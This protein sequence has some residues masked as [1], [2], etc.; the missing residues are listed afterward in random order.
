MYDK[1][2][3]GAA[4]I[5]QRDGIDLV[6]VDDRIFAIPATNRAAQSAMLESKKVLYA[7]EPVDLTDELLTML[8]NEFSAG[9]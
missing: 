6:L 1:I 9:K 4:R 7:S 2:A 3:D 8:N 5:A